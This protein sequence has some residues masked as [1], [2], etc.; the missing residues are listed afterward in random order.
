MIK[1]TFLALVTAGLLSFCDTAEE[2]AEGHFQSGRALLEQGDVDRAL[3]EFRNVFKLN[4]MHHE[5]RLLYAEAERG[6]GNI[7]EAYGQYLRL[8]EQYPDNLP[9]QRALAELSLEVSDW[10]AARRHGAVA[11]G[12]AP[13]DRLVQ[14]VNLTLAYRDAIM[15]N[16]A[17]ARHETVIRAQALVSEDPGLMIARR[18]LIDDLIR[19][20]DWTGALAAIDAA[21]AEASGDRELYTLRLGVLNQLG[22]TREIRAQLE[23]MLGIFPDDPSVLATLVRWYLSQGDIEAADA[24]L[25]ARADS[26]TVEDITTYIRFLSEVRD[27]AT[28]L[29]ELE[30]ILAGD[31]PARAQLT[32]LRAGFRFD[33]GERDA[34]ISGME[35]LIGGMA[36]SDERRSIM[37]MLARMLD[38][39]GNNVGARAL[40]EEVLEQDRSQVEALKMRAGWLIESDR[41]DEAIVALRTALG[42]AP[43]DA[44][45]M[46]LMAQAHERAG[47][48]DLMAEMLSR[49]VEAS[50]NAPEESLRYARYLISQGNRR[51]AETVLINALRLAP[52]SIALLGGLGDVHLGERDW[53]RLDQ[54]IET[55]RRHSDRVTAGQIAN[56]LTAR[57]L[58]AQDRQDELMSFLDG[59]A[60]DGA[61]G[62]AAAAAI[63]RTRL[64]Q[65]DEEGARTYARETLAAN[66]DDLNARFLLASVQAVT[67]ERAAAQAAFRDLTLAAPQDPRFWLALYSI[68]AAQEDP[69]AARQALDDGLAILPGNLRLNWALAG[70]FE[71]EGDIEGAIAIYDRLYAANSSNLII[72]NNLA[73]LLATGREDAESLTRAHEIARRL[74]GREVPAFQ[75][76]Y[77][78]IAFRRGDLDSA[79]GALEPAAAGLPGDASVQYHLA[80]TYAALGREAEALAQ[81]RKVIE[82]VGDGPRPGFMA[83][84]EA[85]IA[86]LATV[87]E[88]GA[89]RE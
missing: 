74:R 39:T 11:A 38:A 3:V 6:R 85:E 28:A 27:R 25:R 88:E 10:D 21:L 55:L 77:G 42:A 15:G 64:T 9:G 49:A 1:P 86:R 23:E 5:A 26:G 14:A 54:V 66:P 22:E 78:W 40:I 51:T 56:E 70:M 32:A 31:P 43:N 76:T 12:L 19:N 80:R 35:G 34:A 24:F 72:A 83:E 73:S 69:A 53:P 30:R 84:V 71:S 7:R 18:V 52:D 44:Q 13:E 81:F 62:M 61:G 33:L 36:P 17:A 41:T 47:N 60:G 79:L 75:D 68:S 63:V 29:A 8:V 45:A 16:D 57:R 20:Q 87:T 46:T 82:I 37:V 89:T 65:G 58:A 2:R 67:G 4:G 48:R 50:R 59:L